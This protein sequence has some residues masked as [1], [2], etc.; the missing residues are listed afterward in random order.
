M[1]HC[2]WIISSEKEAANEYNFGIRRGIQNKEPVIPAA[3]GVNAQGSGDMYPKGGNMLHSIR[4]SMDNDEL[5]RKILV[6][7]NT[8]FITKL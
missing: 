3:Y 4:H 2:L 8:D 6:G 7:L 1:K 5:F